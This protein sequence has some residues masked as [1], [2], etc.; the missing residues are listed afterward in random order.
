MEEARESDIQSHAQLL[1]QLE[2]SPG[3]LKPCLRNKGKRIQTNKTQSNNSWQTTRKESLTSGVDIHTA[4]TVSQFSPG[5][6]EHTWV[7]ML[8]DLCLGNWH[9]GRHLLGEE[10]LHPTH[11]PHIS[12][13]EG[14][15]AGDQSQ[16]TLAIINYTKGKTSDPLFEE[17]KH[18]P[19][20]FCFQ[21]A[22]SY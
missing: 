17:I 13:T 9:R 19:R 18:S 2:V 16:P 12:P 7:N 22:K 3:Y 1:I 10:G 8:M 21:L 5:Q 4:P 6:Q 14:S 15:A 20:Y 11:S